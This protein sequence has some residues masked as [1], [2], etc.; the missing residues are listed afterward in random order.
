MA[1]I[2]QL[3]KMLRWQKRLLVKTRY[4]RGKVRYNLKGEEYEVEFDTSDE[5]WHYEAADLFFDEVRGLH[6]KLEDVFP[7]EVKDIAEDVVKRS[8]WFKIT[9]VESDAEVTE[10][11]IPVKEEGVPV[12]RSEK[13]VF[14]VDGKK[15][16]VEKDPQLELSEE[17]VEKLVRAGLL[18]MRV[19]AWEIYE[20]EP[21]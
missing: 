16:L 15:Y 20:W 18:E 21:K 12:T 13:K 5:D 9:P 14:V 7:I 1:D 6:E 3:I 19:D 10:D 11:W 2:K 4:V 8:L 17:D